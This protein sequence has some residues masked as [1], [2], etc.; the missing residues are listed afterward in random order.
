M[1]CLAENM[2]VAQWFLALDDDVCRNSAVACFLWFEAFNCSIEAELQTGQRIET[3]NVES[4]GH[5]YADNAL[6]AC[7][8]RLELR[9]A[10]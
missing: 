8:S 10:L 6:R 1:T 7:V 5:R 9:F 3:H 4:K 2:S